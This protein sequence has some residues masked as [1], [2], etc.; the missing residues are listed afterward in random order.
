MKL[1]TLHSAK[2]VTWRKNKIP[3]HSLIGKIY[4]QPFAVEGEELLPI[5]NA[6][7]YDKIDSQH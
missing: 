6:V 1:V 3:A 4:G 7:F 2:V 5:P